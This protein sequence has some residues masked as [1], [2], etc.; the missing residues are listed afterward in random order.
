MS[1]FIKSSANLAHLEISVDMAVRLIVES[2]HLLARETVAETA[3]FDAFFSAASYR[4][5]DI[6]FLPFC[7]PA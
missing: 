7:I 6:I 1:F 3:V 2:F 4:H 5:A